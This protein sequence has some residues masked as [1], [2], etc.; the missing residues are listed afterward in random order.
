MDRDTMLALKDATNPERVINE[1]VE[2]LGDETW[3]VFYRLVDELDM[4]DRRLRNI[5]PDRPMFGDEQTQPLTETICD[6]W[7]QHFN[8]VEILTAI[9]MVSRRMGISMNRFRTQEGGLPTNYSIIK[10]KYTLPLRYWL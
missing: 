4:H 10:E 2:N 1:G 6:L 3:L 9:M 7:L 8:D 5:E